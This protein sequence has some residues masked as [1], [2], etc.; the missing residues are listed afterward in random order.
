LRCRRV[1]F[2]KEHTGLVVA[3]RIQEREGA[4]EEREK[5]RERERERG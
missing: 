3:A 2:V 5:E 1:L 4:R